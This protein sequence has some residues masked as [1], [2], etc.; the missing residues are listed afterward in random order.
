MGRPKGSTNKS[1][2][3]TSKSASTAK[4]QTALTFQNKITKPTPASLLGKPTNKSD[5]SAAATKKAALLEDSLSKPPTDVSFPAPESAESPVLEPNEAVKGNEV[6]GQKEK[7]KE[8]AIRQPKAPVVDELEETARK[9]SDAQVR[10]YWK[11]VDDLR[12]AP[13]GE[14]FPFLPSPSPFPCLAHEGWGV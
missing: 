1:S 11:G 2:S 12:M 3:K 9:T 14:L 8:L 7:E 6:E 10:R 4:K 5:P 13:R